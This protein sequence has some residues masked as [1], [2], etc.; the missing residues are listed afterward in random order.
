MAFVR[1]VHSDLVVQR[2]AARSRTA[3]LRG[4]ARSRL[5]GAPAGAVVSARGGRRGL[6]AGA[7]VRLA[8]RSAHA[9][10]LTEV[11]A[12]L[13]LIFVSGS[14][15]IVGLTVGTAVAMLLARLPAVKVVFNIGQYV[16]SH[17]VG[18]LVLRAIAGEHPDFGA[19]TW[20]GTFVAM[21]ISGAVSIAMLTSVITITEGRPTLAEIR[22]MF[23]LDAIVTPA[24]T[25]LA[26]LAAVIVIR[27]PAAVP[28]MIVPL[29]AAAIGSGVRPRAR[30]QREGRV[31]LR[32]QPHA[33][34]LTGDRRRHR[35][36]ARPCA[37]RVPRRPRRDHPVLGT[38]APRCAPA[39]ARTASA[40]RWSRST[41]GPPRR[42]AI[43]AADGPVTLSAP[44]DL[45][46]RAALRGP[47]RPQRHDGGPARRGP[48]RRHGHG[49]QP[50]RDQPQLR[51]R[52]PRAVRHARGQRQR[53]AAVRPPGRG[54][55]RAGGAR[56]APAPP[57]PPRPAHRAGQ[58][59][60]VHR[61]RQR[62]A[63]RAPAAPAVLFV[64]LD[65]FKTVNDTLGHAVG[66]E[67]LR[68]ASARLAAPCAAT[69]LVG[70]ARRR[71]V[72]DPRPRATT[73]P[74]SSRGHESRSASLRS[75]DAARRARR[76]R[77]LAVDA[78][79]G[80][81]AGRAAAAT[82]DLLRDADLAMYE[83]KSRRQAPA[84][85]SSRPRCATP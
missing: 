43:R 38:A 37:R 31:P 12:A 81:A 25:S 33:V 60:P 2:R 26:L 11:L 15:Y 40:T 44:L 32:G 56:A 30:P 18:F 39:S 55:V 14:Q 61:S 54:R 67:L 58:P 75:F 4:G 74:T 21:Q 78:S 41:P 76:T 19:V 27:E 65:D 8:F 82:A 80:V 28:I 24:N 20:I 6:R 9:F 71:R 36:T 7:P 50:R 1:R 84:T 48:H 17:A 5:G 16:L 77:L 52:R 29:A 34:A 62:G 53:R 72:R 70:A 64:D 49:R 45:R 83:A 13:G 10:S 66:D 63:Q 85:R 73:R 47:R 23:R 42:C 79:V 57:G 35:G 68:A 22:Q 46:A 69:D 59:R 3:G 51:Q